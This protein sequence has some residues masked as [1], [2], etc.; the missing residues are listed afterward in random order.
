MSIPLVFQKRIEEIRNDFINGS[1][2]ITRNALKILSDAVQY[3]DF[4][5]KYSVLVI[6]QDLLTTKPQMAAPTNILKIFMSEFPK[7]SNN[8]DITFLINKL[9]SDLSTATEDSKKICFDGLFGESNLSVMTCSFSSN[10]FDIIIKSGTS[11]SIYVLSSKWRSIDFGKIWQNKLEEYK[12]KCKIIEVN[13]KLPKIDFALIGADAVLHK[14]D[15]L[16]GTPS[17]N[18]AE[19]ME[20]NKYPTYVIAES[21]KRCREIPISDG[22]EYIPKNLV[23]KIFS[24]SIFNSI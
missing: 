19:L 10:V 15:V 23:T 11:T 24:D 12:I 20:R 22:F 5:Q 13:G 9:E 8:N 14:G 2:V 3:Y 16:N 1:S 21:F 17:L 4:S 7:F 18:L 6:A